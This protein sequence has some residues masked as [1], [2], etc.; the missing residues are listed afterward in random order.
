MATAGSVARVASRGTRGHRGPQTRLGL[1]SQTETEPE[2]LL[3]P[4]HQPCTYLAPL[5]PPVD[6]VEKVWVP[7]RSREVISHR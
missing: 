4:P 3:L 2:T 5:L 6:N 1:S 7:A